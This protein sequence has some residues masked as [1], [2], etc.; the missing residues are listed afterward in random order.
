M[1]IWFYSF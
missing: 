1:D